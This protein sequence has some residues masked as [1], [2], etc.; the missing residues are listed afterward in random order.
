LEERLQQL[1]V[2]G[3]SEPLALVIKGLCQV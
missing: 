2:N 1:N 3:Y